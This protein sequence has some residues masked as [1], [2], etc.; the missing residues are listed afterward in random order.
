MKQEVY[1]V[2]GPTATGKS[3]LAV[4]L[5]KKLGGE[6]VS[7]DSMQVYRKMDI[8]T[9]KPT[10]E[11]RQGI[12][13]H[14]LDIVDPDE[15]Y[16]VAQ[17]QRQAGECIAD[18]LTRNRVPILAGGSGLYINAIT[19]SL[20]FSGP[21]CNDALREELLSLPGEK[22]F[23]MLRSED[24]EA[25]RRIHPNNVKRVI[26]AIEIARTEPR[27]MPYDFEGTSGEY[28]FRIVGLTLERP[29]LY[30]RIDS[31]VD[32]M[33]ELGLVEEAGMLYNTY[34]SGLPS[35]QAIGYKEFAPYFQGAASLEDVVFTIKRNTRRFAKRQ[36]TWFARD[37][38][39]V[40][41]DVSKYDSACT[42]A[43]CVLE[44]KQ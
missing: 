15:A 44:S 33:M 35:M 27:T 21:A 19:H 20:D 2:C 26:R 41:I 3:A 22:L 16:S 39:I 6:V 30:R 12:A 11:E 36:C 25:A 37:S 34:G 31:R 9:A 17:Y 38:R 29:A 4:A 10:Q 8:G 32:R 14:M 13:H 23:E 7:A 40:W 42:M 28:A 43:D 18:I 24:P 1:V 5:A